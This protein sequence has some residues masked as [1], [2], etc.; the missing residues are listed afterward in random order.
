MQKQSPLLGWC[1]TAQL[2]SKQKLMA[3]LPGKALACIFSF[4]FD[5]FHPDPFPHF[6]KTVCYASLGSLKSHPLRLTQLE[7]F[8][9][10]NNKAF[11]RSQLIFG[12]Q[13]QLGLKLFHIQEIEGPNFTQ[14]FY[15][16]MMLLE[17]LLNEDILS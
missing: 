2:H 15:F 14:L 4:G 11:P 7:N 12:L 6:L 16:T 3:G 5:F 8:P 10:Q 17:A 1:K 9:L 13:I